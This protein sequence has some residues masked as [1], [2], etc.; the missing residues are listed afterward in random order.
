MRLTYLL[1]VF[2]FLQIHLDSPSRQKTYLKIKVL[3]KIQFFTLELIHTCD[4]LFSYLFNYLCRFHTIPKLKRRITKSFLRILL[5][6][7]GDISVNPGPVYNNQSLDS[8]EWNAF[9]SKVI[10]LIYLK[11][12]SI[13]NWWNPPYSCVHQS[14]SNWNNWL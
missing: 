12:N 7:S 8:N 6:L 10:H 14:R 2:T 9:R 5:I 11:V 3:N 13:K 1:N 4:D